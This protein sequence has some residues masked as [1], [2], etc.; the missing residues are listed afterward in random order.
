ML[1]PFLLITKFLFSIWMSPLFKSFLV[2]KILMLQSS[3]YCT[4]L[5]FNI[6]VFSFVSVAQIIIFLPKPN[7]L[8]CPFAVLITGRVTGVYDVP[9]LKSL[10][11]LA[12][13]V[14]AP[15]LNSVPFYSINDWFFLFRCMQRYPDSFFTNISTLPLS[16]L[17]QA[18][19]LFKK[20]L[21][22]SSF[23]LLLPDFFFKSIVLYYVQ[24]CACSL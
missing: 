11:D 8:I 15:I 22:N 2:S 5:R 18:L 10:M 19:L 1:K 14:L 23:L 9:V 17:L 6:Y 24:Y 12:I 13:W 7:G 3:K 4:L 16:E 20:S 21:L